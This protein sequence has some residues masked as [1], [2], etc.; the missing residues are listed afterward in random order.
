MKDCHPN[1]KILQGFLAFFIA[2]KVVPET[3]KPEMGRT[4]VPGTIS[5]KTLPIN[6]ESPKSTNLPGIKNLNAILGV[7]HRQRFDEFLTIKV[8]RF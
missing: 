6:F 3:P 4:S 2:C 5:R 8:V 1:G 7:P